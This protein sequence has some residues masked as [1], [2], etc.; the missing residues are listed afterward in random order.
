MLL[1]N[2]FV[3]GVGFILPPEAICVLL[4]SVVGVVGSL[5][6]VD[7]TTTTAGDL[8]RHALSPT[9]AITGNTNR[10][11]IPLRRLA[12]SRVKRV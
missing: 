5:S 10:T 9:S 2:M 6:N 11:L 12:N 3:E 8:V 4:S 1:H 7:V